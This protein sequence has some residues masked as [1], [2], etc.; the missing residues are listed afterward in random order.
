MQYLDEHHDHPYK[1]RYRRA[2]EKALFKSL[3]GRYKNVRVM[4]GTSYTLRNLRP[5]TQYEIGI[6]DK[7][8]PVEDQEYTTCYAWTMTQLKPELKKTH[9]AK[10]DVMLEAST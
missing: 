3:T 2:E 8:L 4:N 5:D 10:Q 9:K 1:I 7:S 6:V